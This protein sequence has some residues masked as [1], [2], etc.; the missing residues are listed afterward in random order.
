MESIAAATRALADRAVD[1]ARTLT[2][3]GEVA[4]DHQVVVERVAYAAT[5]ARVIDELAALP[6]ELAATARVAIAEL[7][8]SLRFRLEPIAGVLGLPEPRFD[9]APRAEIADA[10]APAGVEAVGARAIADGGR[11]AWPLDETLSEVRANVRA[12]SE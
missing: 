7:A 5:E 2:R 1:A 9:D 8:Q 10:I 6:V 4:D 3:N 12:F 11:I